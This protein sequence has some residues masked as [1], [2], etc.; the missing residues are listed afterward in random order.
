MHDMCLEAVPCGPRASKASK[1][2]SQEQGGGEQLETSVTVSAV[3][4]ATSLVAG[5]G[6]GCHVGKE[7]LQEVVHARDSS[8]DAYIVPAAQYRRMNCMRLH[9]CGLEGHP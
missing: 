7:L 8:S 1:G 3:G 4:V 2:R 5:L 6:L 9:A